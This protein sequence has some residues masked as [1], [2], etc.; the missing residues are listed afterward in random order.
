M[1]SKYAQYKLKRCKKDLTCSDG[2]S[3]RIYTMPCIVLEKLPDNN[4][5]I[6]VFGDRY[7]CY[8][9]TRK[10]LRVVEKGRVIKKRK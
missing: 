1:I 5:R 9:K 6:L 4:R 10:T 2:S 7:G 3:G 8:L